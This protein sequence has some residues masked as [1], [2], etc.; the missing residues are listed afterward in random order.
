MIGK[1]ATHTLKFADDPIRFRATAGMRTNG[2]EQVCRAS[3]VQ[4]VHALAESPQGGRPKIPRARF[5][6]TDPVAEADAQVMHQEARKQVHWHV[7]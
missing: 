7:P 6:L 4:K 1:F 5:A 2:D 3:V